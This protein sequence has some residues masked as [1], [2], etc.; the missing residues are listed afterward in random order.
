MYFI[1]H[2]HMSRKFI[3]FV[4][5]LTIHQPLQ[6]I[7]MIVE[8]LKMGTTAVPE[9]EIKPETTPAPTKD[10]GPDLDPFNPPLPKVNPDPK[11]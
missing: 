10:P 5:Q 7:T 11:N 1:F 6:E 3:K 2:L 8:M 9:P 4:I